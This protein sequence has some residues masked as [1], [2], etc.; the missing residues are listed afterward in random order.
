MV[1]HATHLRL[2]AKLVNLA[3][4]GAGFREIVNNS[5]DQFHIRRN[6]RPY[7]YSCIRA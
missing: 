4:A 3:T 6:D 7:Y 2:P 1:T 5:Q